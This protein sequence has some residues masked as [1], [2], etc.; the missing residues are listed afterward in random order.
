ML[1]EYLRELILGTHRVIK[2]KWKKH[3][4][5]NFANVYTYISISKQCT[6]IKLLTGKIA[7]ML[8]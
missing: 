7:L 3:E 2:H 6:G 5:K 4:M 1:K 8:N